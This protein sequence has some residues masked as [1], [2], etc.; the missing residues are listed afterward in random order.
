MYAFYYRF[1]SFNLRSRYKQITLKLFGAWG[2]SRSEAALEGL[3]A[4]EGVLMIKGDVGLD[5]LSSQ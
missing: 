4:T 3:L 1:Y 2:K 5:S